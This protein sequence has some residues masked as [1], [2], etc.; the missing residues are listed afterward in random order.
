MD[1]YLQKNAFEIPVLKVNSLRFAIEYRSTRF[2]FFFNLIKLFFVICSGIFL[3]VYTET[4]QSVD[5]NDLGVVQKWIQGL[6]A[7]L[8]CFDD[9]MCLLQNWF[10]M[11]YYLCQG[12][13]EY[14]Y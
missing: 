5:R 8:I 11:L 12:F 10:G 3:Y 9:P 6:I 14:I 7:L 13:M 4:L 2:I 1:P